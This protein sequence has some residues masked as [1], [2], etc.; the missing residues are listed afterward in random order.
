M[1]LALVW[2]A[3]RR[4]LAWG[5]CGQATTGSTAHSGASGCGL[6]LGQAGCICR[7]RALYGE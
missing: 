7:W 1:C 2:Q 5:G 3:H 4:C 6:V